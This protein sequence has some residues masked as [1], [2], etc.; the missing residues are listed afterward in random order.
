MSDDREHLQFNPVKLIKACPR[1][2]L[3]ESLEEL[4]HR[5]VVQTIGTVKHHTL[6]SHCLGQIL[7][8][9][10]LAGSSGALRGSPQ[11]QLDGAHQGTV[12]PGGKGSDIQLA[13]IGTVTWF[14]YEPQ[15]MN[16]IESRPSDNWGS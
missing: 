15:S 9:L 16:E 14:G 7:T 10:G 6:F 8:R 4:A 1:S 13:D 12:T 5:F 3:C 2:R 11:G